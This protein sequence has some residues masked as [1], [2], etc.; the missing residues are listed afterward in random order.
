MGFAIEE[1]LERLLRHPH[2]KLSRSVV[3]ALRKNYGQKM[4]KRPSSDAAANANPESSNEKFVGFGD[5]TQGGDSP[6]GNGNNGSAGGGGGGDLETGIIGETTRCLNNSVDGDAGVRK[7][8][9]GSQGWMPFSANMIVRISQTFVQCRVGGDGC[10]C[11]VSSCQGW[12]E[13]LKCLKSKSTQR[14]HITDHHPHPVCTYHLGYFG[15]V[16]VFKCIN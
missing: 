6:D 15:T 9:G 10:W 8:S 3:L 11:S 13:M 14:T 7:D 16:G 2:R 5:V 1:K 4:K 12:A